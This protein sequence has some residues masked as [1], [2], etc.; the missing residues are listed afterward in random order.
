MRTSL[1]PCLPVSEADPVRSSLQLQLLSRI[2]QIW[3]PVDSKSTD[4]D[5][6]RQNGNNLKQRQPSDLLHSSRRNLI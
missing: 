6:E 1:C 4:P 5:P 2:S 3:L